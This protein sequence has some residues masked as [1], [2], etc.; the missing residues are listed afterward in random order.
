MSY[1]LCSFCLKRVRATPIE[2]L[3]VLSRVLLVY[4]LFGTL[5]IGIRIC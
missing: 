5:Q 2:A 1:Q 3:V 4:V